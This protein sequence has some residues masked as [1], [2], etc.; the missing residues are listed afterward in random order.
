MT[1][2]TT[3]TTNTTAAPAEEST[4]ARRRAL[5]RVRLGFVGI[6]IG[7]RYLKIAQVESI[8][9][10]YRLVA[11]EIVKLRSQAGNETGLPE[12][13]GRQLS[14]AVRS[15][16]FRGREAV[17]LLPEKFYERDALEFSNTG[18][19]SAETIV[20]EHLATKHPVPR[21]HLMSDF[22]TFPLDD[23]GREQ[24][25]I[26]SVSTSVVRQLVE[27]LKPAGLEI[28]CLDSPSTVAARAVRTAQSPAIGGN[29]ALLDWGDENA[30]FTL[31]SNGVPI[32]ARTLRDSG[33]RRITEAVA[34]GIG[35]NESEAE[36][37]LQRYGTVDAS[38]RDSRSIIAAELAANYIEVFR[39]YREELTRTCAYLRRRFP[40]YPPEHLMLLGGGALQSKLRDLTGDVLGL[41]PRLWSTPYYTDATDSPIP[42]PLFANAIA[43]STLAF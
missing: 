6:D 12:D 13:L 4:R 38:S 29:V 28:H 36:S 20:A 11:A 30:T 8:G 16:R 31:T 41:E 14:Q 15:A 42:E 21:A 25:E 5:R 40:Q 26:V 10:H 37:L 17:C 19:R 33:S 43:L 32:F 39:G 23:E 3:E 7:T 27:E 1:M 9:S 2:S 24:A 18:G 35:L 34:A 22:W